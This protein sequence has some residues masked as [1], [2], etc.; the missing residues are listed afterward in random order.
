MTPAHMHVDS[1]L[2]QNKRKDEIEKEM[3]WES[4]QAKGKELGEYIYDQDKYMIFLMNFLKIKYT[5]Q[6]KWSFDEEEGFSSL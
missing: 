3:S 6:R 1:G 5:S 4:R 2:F